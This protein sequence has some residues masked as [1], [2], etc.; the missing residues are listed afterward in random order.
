MFHRWAWVVSCVLLAN[1]HFAWA[2]DDDLSDIFGEDDTQPRTAGEERRAL[3][4]EADM[5]AEAAYS[6]ENATI[7]TLQRKNF[8]KI[9]RYEISGG[10][11]FVTNDPFLNRYLGRLGAVYHITEILGIEGA[12]MF[13]PELGDADK[14]PIT[15]QLYEFNKVSPDISKIQFAADMGFQFSPIY[16]KVAV[17]GKNIVNF[18]IFGQ[19]GTGVV[20]TADDLEA[21]GEEKNPAAIATQGQLHPTLTYGGGIRVILS[22]GF[23]TRVEARGMSYIEVLEGHTLEMK[24]NMALLVSASWIVP[25]ME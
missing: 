11:G 19:F 5:P 16:G 17:S 8:V 14:K 9:D 6:R 25:G 23:A 10:A 4:S 24:N 13:S 1:T 2:Q 20:R 22:L 21:I 7:K 3:E 12:F 15:K 18:D